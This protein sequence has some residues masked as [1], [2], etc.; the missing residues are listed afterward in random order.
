MGQRFNPSLKLHAQTTNCPADAIQ[1]AQTRMTL[2]AGDALR[3]SAKVR[4]ACMSEG[5]VSGKTKRRRGQTC[6]RSTWAHPSRTPHT[7]RSQSRHRTQTAESHTCRCPAHTCSRSRQGRLCRAHRAPRDLRAD[8]TSSAAACSMPGV[9]RLRIGPAM[10]CQA[11]STGTA[12][13][14]GPFAFMAPDLAI[15]TP[16]RYTLTLCTVFNSVRRTGRSEDQRK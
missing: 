6:R 3:K 8:G 11:G 15:A 7:A 5:T 13:G 4:A 10:T 14:T 2:G 12:P 1:Q 9:I 16:A